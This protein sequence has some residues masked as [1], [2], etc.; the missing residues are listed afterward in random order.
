MHDTRSFR[1]PSA[2]EERAPYEESAWIVERA[3]AAWPSRCVHDLG[4]VG[5]ALKCRP[6]T[7]TFS[8]S[9]PMRSESHVA[10]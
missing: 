8:S 10:T 2:G 7:A 6:T 9:F 1:A 4:S 5:K 3:V